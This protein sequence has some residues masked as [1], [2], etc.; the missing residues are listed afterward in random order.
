[1]N[2]NWHICIEG[3]FE[4]CKCTLPLFSGVASLNSHVDLLTTPWQGRLKGHK[5]TFTVAHR[6]FLS[7]ANLLMFCICRC[8][9]HQRDEDRLLQCLLNDVSK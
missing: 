8:R 2:K 9:Q 5:S 1:M 7:Q 3:P 4:S 6:V